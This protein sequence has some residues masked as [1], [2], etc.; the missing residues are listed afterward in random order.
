MIG[1][2]G[3]TQKLYGNFIYS[4]YVSKISRLPGDLRDCVP[5]G[6]EITMDTIPLTHRGTLTANLFL[7]GNSRFASGIYHKTSTI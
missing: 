4:Y 7:R 5:S 2:G 3:E 1:H 6:R